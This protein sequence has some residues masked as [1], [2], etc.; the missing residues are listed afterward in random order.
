M[1]MEL[2][3]AMAESPE[4]W[5]EQAEARLRAAGYRDS[6][7]PWP[8]GGAVSV[9]RRKDFRVEWLLTQLHTFVVLAPAAH[10][11]PGELTAF[12]HAAL[13]YAKQA[14][15]G[16]P[17]GMQ[18]G[19]AVLPVLVAGSADSDAQDEARQRPQKDF[20]A[21]RLPVLVDL[22]ADR[23][24]TYSGPMAWGLAYR[25]FLGDQ[26]RAVI[27]GVSGDTLSHSGSAGRALRL[28]AVAGFLGATLAAL[29]NLLVSAFR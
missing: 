27:G 8:H 1:N 17:I 25:D 10:A 15:G 19:V 22:G 4:R 12:T 9:L 7:V 29:V 21:F 11:V 20:G 13:N 3:K 26:Q 5:I 24:L 6:K 14:K 23:A 2:G 18:T 16:L 28:V